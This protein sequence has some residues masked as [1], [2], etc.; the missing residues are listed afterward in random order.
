MAE[1]ELEVTY[2]FATVSPRVPPLSLGGPGRV[3]ILRPQ[4]PSLILSLQRFVAQ[5]VALVEILHA[6]FGIKSPLFSTHDPQGHWFDIEQ[7][8]R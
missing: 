3:P 5:S 2:S 1:V 4:T 7:D 6:F 8:R